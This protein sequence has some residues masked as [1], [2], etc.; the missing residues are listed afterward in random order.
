MDLTRHI[1]IVQRSLQEALLVDTDAE[2]TGQLAVVIVH[3]SGSLYW[4]GTVPAKVRRALIWRE[5][6]ICAFELLAALM[7]LI[8]VY[9][10]F[11]RQSSICHFIDSTVALSVMIKGQASTAT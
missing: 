10:R 6:Q 1:P 7:G 9:E 5:T 3:A 4:V 8:V 11:G 2:S